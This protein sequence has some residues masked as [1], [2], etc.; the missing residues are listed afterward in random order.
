LSDSKPG[1]LAEEALSEARPADVDGDPTRVFSAEHL[2]VDKL[3][4]I[5]ARHGLAAR[6]ASFE[7]K[8]LGDA[9]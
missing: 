2:D 9:P 6:W 4:A 7:K 8:F 1:P 5:L 3:Q